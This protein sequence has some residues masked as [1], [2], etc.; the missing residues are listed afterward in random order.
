MLHALGPELDVDVIQQVVQPG[1]CG[2]GAGRMTVH[3]AGLACTSLTVQTG[4]AS[5]LLTHQVKESQRCMR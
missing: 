4:V 1:A 3:P 2:G 5:M